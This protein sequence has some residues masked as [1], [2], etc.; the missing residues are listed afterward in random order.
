MDLIPCGVGG[1]GP[2]LSWCVRDSHE[3][4][5]N[6]PYLTLPYDGFGGSSDPIGNAFKT[7]V[8]AFQL[9]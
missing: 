1:K 4:S 2:Q 9:D 7:I 6:L 8:A 3:K 5:Q